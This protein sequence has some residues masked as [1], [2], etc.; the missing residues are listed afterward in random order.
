MALIPPP[1]HAFPGEP[2][3]EAIAI[4]P[5]AAATETTNTTTP[6]EVADTAAATVP[7]PYIHT[8]VD[9]LQNTESWVDRCCAPFKGCENK[10]MLHG[11]IG[12]VEGLSI[13]AGLIFHNPFLLY[14]AL[15]ATSLHAAGLGARV[16]YNN[17]VDINKRDIVTAAI[18]THEPVTG[19]IVGT[20]T[21]INRI[22]A[23]Y[24]DPDRPTG[25]TLREQIRSTHSLNDTPDGVRL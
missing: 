11:A 17:C 10:I 4:N 9:G 16:Q 3:E 20:P 14:P 7:A 18:A 5:F 12:Y 1:A 6:D 24:N 21:E 13:L 19:V 23:F 15:A 8:E 2:T 25:Y 22:G